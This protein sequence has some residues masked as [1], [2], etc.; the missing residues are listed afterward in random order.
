MRCC[1]FL[2]NKTLKSHQCD[3]NVKWFGQLWTQVSFPNLIRRNSWILSHNDFKKQS[4]KH[5]ISTNKVDTDLR[6]LPVCR[7]HSIIYVS[8]EPLYNKLSSGCHWTQFTPPLWPPSWQRQRIIWLTVV[9]KLPHYWIKHLE[10]AHAIRHDYCL[11]FL[12]LTKA[13]F[14]YKFSSKLEIL[15][16][17]INIYIFLTF[18]SLNTLLASII[19]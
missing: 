15:Q 12:T 13:F 4:T 19:I 10:A 6:V 3:F 16:T 5:C 8:S 1:F 9:N 11:T 14:T 7:S 17:L 18:Y 2:I